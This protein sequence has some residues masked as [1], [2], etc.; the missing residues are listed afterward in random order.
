[1]GSVGI[2]VCDALLVIDALTFFYLSDILVAAM[3]LSCTTE[4]IL[5]IEPN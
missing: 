5:F 2:A 1:M 3:V 4:I